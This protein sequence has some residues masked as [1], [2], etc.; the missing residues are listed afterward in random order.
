MPE[1]GFISNLP[2]ALQ[3]EKIKNLTDTIEA[4][5]GRRPTSYRS[6]RWAFNDTVAQQLVRLGYQV[7]TSV[8]PAWDWR[9]LGGNDDSTWSHEPYVYRAQGADGTAGGSLLEVPATVGFLQSPSGLARAAF[10]VLKRVPAGD[11]VTA[12]LRRLGMLNHVCVS[13]EINGAGD[14]IKLAERLLARGTKVINMFFHSPT[15]LEGCSPFARSST[16]VAAFVARIDEFLTFARSAGL[17]SVTMSEL[18]PAAAGATR[19]RLLPASS[20]VVE[21]KS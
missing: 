15:L 3:F 7:D 6:G 5:F 13:P 18:T 1:D 8:F 12:V 10:R 16:D 11:Q 2:A 19:S 21:V 4:N 17:R 14:M 20:A 9:G